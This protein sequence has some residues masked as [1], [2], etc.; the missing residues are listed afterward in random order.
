[1]RRIHRLIEL[2][3]GTRDTPK[4]HVVL[5]TNAIRRRALIEGKRLVHEGRL[6]AAEEIFNLTFR[7][8]EAA[9]GNPALNYGGDARSGRASPGGLPPT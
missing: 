1:M 3:G 7:D 6:D 9:E 8:L 5:L 2:F 4:H